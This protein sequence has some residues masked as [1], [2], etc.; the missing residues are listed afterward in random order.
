MPRSNSSF[1]VAEGGRVV[2][3]ALAPARGRAV[4]AQLRRAAARR[5]RIARAAEIERLARTAP[6][7][8]ADRRF[9]RRSAS[10]RRRARAARR[11]R[12]DSGSGSKAS[13]RRR[14][15]ACGAAGS[16]TIGA[17]DCDL[18]L[19][20]VAGLGLR[21]ACGC[22][23]LLRIALL[24]LRRG[25]LSRRRGR[26][27]VGLRGRRLAARRRRR[28]AELAQPIFKLAVA[29][30]QLLVLA[31]QLPELVFQ[32]LDPHLHIGVVGLRLALRIAFAA[33]NVPTGT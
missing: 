21:I 13:P 17:G 3:A 6:A 31:G 32:P 11:G 23:C 8:R 12:W 5:R 28:G 2:S 26:G 33:A 19:L 22:G 15:P 30:L 20:V 18:R 7:R 16:C 25:G 9:V 24:P 4:A 27:H 10:G 1:G 14:P 29:V